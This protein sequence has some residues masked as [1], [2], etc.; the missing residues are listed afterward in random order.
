MTYDTECSYE[1]IVSQFTKKDIPQRFPI[2]LM[3]HSF[4]RVSRS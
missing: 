2:T 1:K 3:N 4:Q